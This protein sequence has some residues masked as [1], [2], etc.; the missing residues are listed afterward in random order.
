MDSNT[1][2][3][4]LVLI[5]LAGY[6]VLVRLVLWRFL[7]PFARRLLAG[8]GILSGTWSLLNLATKGDQTFWG[9]FFSDNAEL[10]FGSMYSSCL[11][12]L[13]ALIALLNA[14]RPASTRWRRLFWLV[15]V[16][17]FVFMS[18]DEYYSFHE[19]VNSWRYLYAG[20]GVLLVTAIL[21]LS[22]L[23][24]DFKILLF[25]VLGI[26]AIGLGGVV[27]DAFANE[28]YL[29]AAGHRIGWF[30][31]R[32]PWHGIECQ[33]F[34]TVEELLETLGESLVLAGFLSFAQTHHPPLRWRLTRR[35]L[36]G[37]AAG[38]VLWMCGSMWL[39]PT[40]EA[41]ALGEPV[42]VEYLN[43]ALD[44][45]DYR[46]SRDVAAPGDTID[47]TL[48]LRTDRFIH[49]DYYLSVHLL[50]QTDM[51]SLAQA[52]FQLGEWNY[53]TSAWIPHLAVR[54]TAHLKLPDDLATPASYWIMVRVWGGPDLTPWIKKPPDYQ[55]VSRE[56]VITATDRRTL[57]QDMVVLTTLPVLG[58]APEIKPPTASDYRFDNGME[59]YGYDLP[60]SA[61]TDQPLDVRFWWKTHQHIRA[62]L[63]QYVHFFEDGSDGFFV[64]SQQGFGGNFPFS[65][66]PDGVDAVD[67]WRLTL[68][69][70]MPPG[71]YHVYTGVYYT[72]TVERIP[73]SD[74]AGQPVPDSSIFLGTIEIKP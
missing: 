67:T 61:Q 9:W 34:G 27:L 15:P 40:L 48:Y 68:P 73:V 38:W 18:L 25:A 22:A 57:S 59:L 37:L 20:S 53:P 33:S 43:G 12:M 71:T 1:R 30:I 51:S 69:A 24:R 6:A 64:F 70:D 17:Y 52:D 66:W 65:D 16:A 63:T 36:A 32:R 74:G 4:I 11:L 14:L 47:V 41:A 21:I 46:L 13:A 23:E 10:T 8:L 55:I 39:V 19:T 60:G 29:S 50:S 42:K 28:V 5:L 62:D 54:N 72:P 49:D 7:Q 31:C 35:A 2:L 45:E 56:I 58:S 26:G 3:T 44:L